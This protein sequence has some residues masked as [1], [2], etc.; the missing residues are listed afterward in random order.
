[1]GLDSVIWGVRLWIWLYL[2]VSIFAVIGSFAYWFKETIKKHYFKTK[3]PEKVIKVV[4]HYKSN[5]YRIYWRIVP[6]NKCFVIEKKAYNYDDKAVMKDNDFFI[7]KDKNKG[8]QFISIDEKQYDFNDTFGIKLRRSDVMEIHYWHNNP[9]PLE[10][11]FEKKKLEFSSKHLQDFKEN[12]L[13]SKLLTLETEK[14][15][16]LILLMA[17]GLN[18]IITGFVLAK[19]MGW[20][21]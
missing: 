19:I 2:I 20:I 14:R 15:M 13:F 11:N 21:E 4:I 7:K 1:M 5:L 17:V 10:F 16:M 12:D 18:I 8:K 6:D 9:S 3:F